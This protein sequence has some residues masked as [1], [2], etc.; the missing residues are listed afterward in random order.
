[1]VIQLNDSDILKEI[2][3]KNYGF[4]V[5]EANEVTSGTSEAKKVASG[6]SE[7]KK[8]ASGWEIMSK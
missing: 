5:S 8:V 3:A 2:L 1:M 7:A 6:I 4:S